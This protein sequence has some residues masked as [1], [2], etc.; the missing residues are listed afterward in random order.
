MMGSAVADTMRPGDHVCWTYDDDLTRDEALASY[1]AAAARDRDKVLCLVDDLAR[2]RFPDL[3]ARSGIDTDDLIRI[4]QLEICT[5]DDTY[6]PTGSFD[7]SEMIAL[8][9]DASATARAQGFRSLR[10]VGDMTWA[11]RPAP[12][13]ERLD[14]YEA[15]VNQVYAEGSAMGLCLYDRRRFGRDRLAAVMQAHPGCVDTSAESRVFAAPAPDRWAPLLRMTWAH[16]PRE[17]VLAGES[18]LSNRAAL[19]AMLDR[20]TPSTDARDGCRLD[21]AGLRFLDVGA[22]HHVVATAIRLGGLHVVGAVPA[23]ARVLRFVATD[24]VPGLI[25]D[26]LG[27]GA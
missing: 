27:A 3:L 15:Q 25:L 12:G 5:A 8:C 20:L 11:T 18:D 2:T 24:Q 4:G 17:L 19:R 21:V 23:V 9:A 26:P 7:P 16:E 14:W 10:A 13:T 6:L 22:A 1:V